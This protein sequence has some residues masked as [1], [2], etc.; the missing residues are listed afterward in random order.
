MFGNF[1]W[2]ACPV[3]RSQ[4][5]GIPGNNLLQPNSTCSLPSALDPGVCVPAVHPSVRRRL[6]IQHTI[7]VPI[8]ID[9]I[10]ISCIVS[11]VI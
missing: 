7:T 8:I 2:T 10:I 9:M 6:S 11:T 5:D 4:S 3:D 1:R